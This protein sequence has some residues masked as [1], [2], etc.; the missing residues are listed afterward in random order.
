VSYAVRDAEATEGLVTVTVP[1]PGAAITV[2]Q[3][4]PEILSELREALKIFPGEGKEAMNRRKEPVKV[5][6]RVKAAML[7]KSL[8]LP[9][10]EGKILLEAREEI[11]LVDFEAEGKRREYYVQVMG[12]GG[13]E[14]EGY[15]GM[16]LGMMGGE[17]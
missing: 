12:E 13:G 3:P 6:A 14:E 5:G 2:I 7:G 4:M 9:I 15:G 17:E 8:S 16:P 1:G 11:I 10:K